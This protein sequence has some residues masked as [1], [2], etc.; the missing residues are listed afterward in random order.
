MVPSFFSQEKQGL[1]GQNAFFWEDFLA[2]LRHFPKYF[3]ATSTKIHAF[4][5]FSGALPEKKK[6]GKEDQGYTSRT[7]LTRM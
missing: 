1:E 6:Q 4:W 5:W 2:F 3:R 7:V